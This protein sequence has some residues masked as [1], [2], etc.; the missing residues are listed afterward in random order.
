MESQQADADV[1]SGNRALVRILALPWMFGLFHHQEPMMSR[2][3]VA[4]MTV[5]QRGYRWCGLP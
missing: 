3:S 4:R 1:K 2:G 5:L